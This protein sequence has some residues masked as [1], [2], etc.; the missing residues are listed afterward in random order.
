MLHSPRAYADGVAAHPVERIARFEK[1]RLP[2]TAL[3]ECAVH[4]QGAARLK[5]PFNLKGHPINAACGADMEIKTTG[6][7]LGV[8]LDFQRRQFI[9]RPSPSHLAPVLR[10]HP[11]GNRQPV[12][13]PYVVPFWVN[14]V[15]ALVLHPHPFVGFGKLF[16][17]KLSSGEIG[18]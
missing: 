10:L 7:L 18:R 15:A 5:D 8:Q 17:D 1:N 6:H 4:L 12:D 9:R 13:S 2:S 3:D 14:A 11:L 16:T